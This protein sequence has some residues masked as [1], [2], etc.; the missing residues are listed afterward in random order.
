MTRP[1]DRSNPPEQAGEEQAARASGSSAATKMDDSQDGGAHQNA[2]ASAEELGEDTSMEEEAQHSQGPFAAMPKWALWILAFVTLYFLIVAIGVIGDGFSAVGEDT[3]EAAFEFA[4]NPFVGLFVGILATVLVQSSSTTTAI[5]VA[6]VGSGALPVETAVPVIMGANIGTTVTNTLASLGFAGNRQEFRRA[7]S[8]AL[9][10]DFYNMLAVVI[11]FTVEVIF[12]PIQRSAKWVADQL[13]GTVLPDPDDADFISAITDPVADLIGPEGLAGLL[14]NDIAVGV[15][16]IILGVVMIFVAIYL[17]G[18]ILQ[19]IMVGAARKYL[20]KAVGGNPI[21][22]MG[23][24]AGI[25]VLIQSS[26][27][28]TST[29]VPFAGAGTLS[30]KDIYPVT[31][32]ANLGTTATGLIAALAVT[33]GGGLDALTIALVH[34]LYNLYGIIIIYGLPFLRN[35][36]VMAANAMGAIVADRR[37]VAPAWVLTLWVALPALVVGVVAFT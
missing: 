16:S 3:A 33:G 2:P 18:K 37:W 6:A 29:L 7:F 17:L 28:T 35:L 23:V 4:T 30:T 1:E 15:G 5:T 13:Y 26:S 20:K 21:V 14:G 25:T 36:P 10:H 11:L 9:V 32:G 34:T 19:A 31:L 27:V 24:G 12:Q 8:A 22:S